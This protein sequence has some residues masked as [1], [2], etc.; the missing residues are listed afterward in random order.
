MEISDGGKPLWYAVYTRPRE[1]NRA[2]SNLRA[3]GLTTF[4]PKVK[5]NRFNPFTTRPLD[6]IEPLFPRYL[7]ANFDAATLL[8]KVTFTRGVR[9]VV[10]FGSSPTSVNEEVIGQI[11]SQTD[12]NGVVVFDNEIKNGDKVTIRVGPFQNLC[13]TA[14]RYDQD[15]DKLLILLSS[16]SYQGRLLINRSFVRKA[17]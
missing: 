16:V 15:L 11:R 7:F 12:V 9:S 10:G 2:E 3:W 4:M 1:E 13:G 8:H 14:E 17:E 5:G 6:T